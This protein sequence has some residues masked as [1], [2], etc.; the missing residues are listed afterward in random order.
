MWPRWRRG[1][2]PTATRWEHPRAGK[3]V[4][5]GRASAHRGLER[6]LRRVMRLIERTIDASTARLLIEPS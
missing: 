4:T 3:R 1:S 6:P 2:M 5:C